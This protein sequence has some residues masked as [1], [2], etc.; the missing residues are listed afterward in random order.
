[1]GFYPVD[2]S[3]DVYVLGSPVF[4]EASIRL[5]NGRTLEIVARGNS[6]TNI[7]IQSATLNGKPWT[8]PW[9]SHADVKDGARL[10]LIMGARPNPNWGSAVADAPPSLSPPAS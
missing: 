2:P 1:M 8:K 10:E 4:D 5:G 7:Y 3:S 9:F 6:P